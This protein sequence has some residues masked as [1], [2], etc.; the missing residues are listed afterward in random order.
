MEMNEILAS[1]LSGLS[2]SLYCLPICYL[3]IRFIKKRDTAILTM[4]ILLAP[5]LYFLKSPLLLAEHYGYISV[6]L[7]SPD[8]FFYDLLYYPFT[9]VGVFSSLFLVLFFSKGTR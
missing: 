8:R 1:I 2:M 9:I 6:N 5:V 4:V 3:I 7:L